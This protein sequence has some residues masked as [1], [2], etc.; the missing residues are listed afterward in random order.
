MQS[1]AQTV[2]AY[3]KELP[4]DRRAAISAVREVIRANLDA[5]LNEGMRYGMIGYYVPHSLDPA[6]HHC[7]P[8]QPLT[9]AGLASQ[10]N[11]LPVSLMACDGNDT[12][13]TWLQEQFR[14]AGK[15]LDQ[16]KSCIRFKQPEDL[17]LEVIGAAFRRLPVAKYI[18]SF[19]VALA[20]NAAA[21]V[22]R[23]AKA[24]VRNT[25]AKKATVKTISPKKAAASSAKKSVGKKKTS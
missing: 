24:P 2:V 18:A 21:R 15:K 7:D 9:H 8:K 6:G 5:D 19:E 22:A 14:K 20:Q 11:N 23:T 17:P 4:D 25:L 13:K 10:K 12:E 3:L 16:G 1:K